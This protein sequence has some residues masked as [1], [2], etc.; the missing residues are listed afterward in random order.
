MHQKGNELF[1]SL[2]SAKNFTG[3]VSD[4][5]QFAGVLRKLTDWILALSFRLESVK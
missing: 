1:T 4:F 2:G 3:T 5:G